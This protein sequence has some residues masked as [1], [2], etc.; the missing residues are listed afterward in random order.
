[1][2][3]PYMAARPAAP[4]A[5]RR[6][7]RLGDPGGAAD[8]APHGTPLAAAGAG[9]TRSAEDAQGARQLRSGESGKGEV[10]SGDVNEAEVVVSM[11]GSAVES[12]GDPTKV[13]LEA[14][15]RP[16]DIQYI[17]TLYI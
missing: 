15:A 10:V 16:V 14:R 6:G 7:Q 11:L 13:L 8:R 5:K 2:G 12:T 1:M 3:L 4:R 17:M 9:T